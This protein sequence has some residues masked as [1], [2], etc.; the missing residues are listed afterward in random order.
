M[1]KYAFIGTE[2]ILVMYLT[3]E[4]C[5]H[6]SVPAK[7]LVLTTFNMQIN[8][9]KMLNKIAFK[10]IFLLITLLKENFSLLIC[11]KSKLFTFLRKKPVP[12]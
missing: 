7:I 8:M 6:A 11:S 4:I 10:E 12:R 9:I 5:S 3:I 2:L 1:P